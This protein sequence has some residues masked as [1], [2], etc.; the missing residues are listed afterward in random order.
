[1]LLTSYPVNSD[2]L[3]SPDAVGNHVFSPGLI[4]LGPADG[5]QAHIHPID[6]IIL[7]KRKQTSW[8][9]K[10]NYNKKVREGGKKENFTSVEIYAN[11]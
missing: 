1:M 7:Y 6:C 8:S 3:H 5:T 10:G 4:S 11:S 9:I 2:P